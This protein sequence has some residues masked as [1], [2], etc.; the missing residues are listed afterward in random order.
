MRELFLCLML[1]S[2]ACAPEAHSNFE[3]STQP[4]T[5]QGDKWKQLEPLVTYVGT[6]HPAQFSAIEAI[7]PVDRYAI[8]KLW[9]NAKTHPTALLAIG[10]L[11]DE[12]DMSRLIS[13]IKNGDRSYA[14]APE[15][16]GLYVGRKASGE[17]PG[18]EVLKSCSKP[19]WNMDIYGDS[20]AAYSHSIKCMQGLVLHRSE[21]AMR[22]LK[23]LSAQSHLESLKT[24]GK[25][26]RFRVN[27]LANTILLRRLQSHG[28]SIAYALETEVRNDPRM[29]QVGLD[30]GIASKELGISSEELY[31]D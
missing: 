2:W 21:E 12:F 17:H 25:D 9:G 23:E 7:G 4:V 26:S 3:Q 20:D 24:K 22:H 31:G 16:L 6:E 13:L 8:D 27:A 11:G 1:T 14:R 30:L 18:L 5:S 19:S 10:I 28:G 15:S 29:M